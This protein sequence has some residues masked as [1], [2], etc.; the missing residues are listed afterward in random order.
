MKTYTNQNSLKGK[1]LKHSAMKIKYSEIDKIMRIA[2]I[3]LSGAIFIVMLLLSYIYC[4]NYLPYIEPSWNNVSY[5]FDDCDILSKNE[6]KYEVDKLFNNPKYNLSE[7]NLQGESMGYTWLFKRQ[8]ILEQNQSVDQYIHTLAHELVHL[9]YFC[10]N[11][12]F[13][14]FKAFQILYES[15]NEFLK[16]CALKHANYYFAGYGDHRYDYAGY[17][18]KYLQNKIN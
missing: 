13:T 2:I 12:R 5:T 7:Q 9:V 15:G 10:G 11:E 8:I 6:I 18:Q 14:N 1:L 3:C 17:V 16:N 4:F